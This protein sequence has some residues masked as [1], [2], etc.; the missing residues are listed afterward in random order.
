MDKDIFNSSSNV[1]GSWHIDEAIIT[2]DDLELGEAI[3]TQGPK[4]SSLIALGFNLQ[5]SRSIQPFRPINQAGTY[6]VGGRGS[7]AVQLQTL[8]GPSSTIEKFIQKYG[9]ICKAVSNTF[10]IKPGGSKFCTSQ[11]Q[12]RTNE[13]LRTPSE[14]VVHGAAM[15]QL[16]LSVTNVGELQVVTSAI[17]MVFTEL[18]VKS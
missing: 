3:T 8:I 14:F 9:D 13:V 16:Q 6:L 7:G 2:F 17:S 5:Y 4:A 12:G 15:N 10:T 1:R 18:K 11:G